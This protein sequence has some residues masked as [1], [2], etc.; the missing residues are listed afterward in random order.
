MYEK[1]RIKLLCTY[2]AVSFSSNK[3]KDETNHRAQHYNNHQSSMNL[4]I[5]E[6]FERS[7]S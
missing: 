3:Y 4:N 2:A 5:Q 1:F 6:I 7:D